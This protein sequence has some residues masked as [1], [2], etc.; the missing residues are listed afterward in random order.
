MALQEKDGRSVFGRNIRNILKECHA[1]KF[2]E[3]KYIYKPV[4][5]DQQWRVHLLKELI[6]SKAYRYDCEL[7][8][9]QIS[10]IIDFVSIN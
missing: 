1:E 10:E 3:A 9:Q 5:D 4:P 6:E 8:R 2:S 7:S